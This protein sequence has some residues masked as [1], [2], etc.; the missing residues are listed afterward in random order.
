[1]LIRAQHLFEL[2]TRRS[3]SRA[4]YVSTSEAVLNYEA[5]AIVR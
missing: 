4:P 2:E 5:V 1:M 3:R